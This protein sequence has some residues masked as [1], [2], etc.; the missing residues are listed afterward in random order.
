MA[1]AVVV[2]VAGLA[3]VEDLGR[4][5]HQ[6]SGVPV[7]GAFDRYAHEAA[8]ALV[9]GVVTDAGIEVLGTLVLRT[10]VAIT[11]AVTGRARAFLEST[12]IPT[13]TAVDAPAGARLSVVAEGRGYLAVTGGVRVT[14]VLGSRSTCL[15]SGLGPRPLQAGDVL[16]LAESP[17]SRTAG[18]FARPPLRT[19][20]IRVVPGP[21]HRIPDGPVQ[22]V[23][24]SRVGVRVRPARP[25]AAI[26]TL[27]SLGVV[28]GT[29]QALPSG[30]WMVLG[31]DAGTMGGYPVVGVVGDADLDRWAQVGPGD[32]L[33]LVG[34]EA[35]SLPEPGHAAVVRVYQLGG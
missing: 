3:L 17:R 19:G 13:W 33:D 18:D 28:P 2:E 12:E 7:S 8:T 15:L 21:H 20:P 35:D 29:I 16:P 22:V 1:Q 11:C 5:G 34:V 10:Q 25:L 4:A 31:P 26:G 27:A 24:G 30:D 23:D 32:R 6:N 9:G 14:P